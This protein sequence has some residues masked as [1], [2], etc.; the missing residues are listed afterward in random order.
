MKLRFIRELFAL[1]V[2]AVLVA[3]VAFAKSPHGITHEE[4]SFDWPD[5]GFY[6]SCL[7]DT[8]NGT[9]DVTTRSHVFETPSGVVHV[10][11]GFFGTGHVYSQTTGRT[12]TV[13]FAIPGT[14]SM[15][16]GKGQT[17][18]WEDNENYIPDEPGGQHFFIRATYKLT[19]NANGD[20]VVERATPDG[21][22][23]FPDDYTR[24]VGSH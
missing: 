3:G 14:A 12:W 17:V 24:C 8:L 15:K 11:E 20:L 22:L 16:V 19:V 18:Q 1:V 13:R 5:E 7:N 2:T 9:I 4:W 10:V 23:V 21:A 6:F